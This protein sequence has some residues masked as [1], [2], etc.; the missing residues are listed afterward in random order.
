MVDS[1]LGECELEGEGDGTTQAAFSFH[2]WEVEWRG[3][4]MMK[5]M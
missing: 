2:E 1:W 4:W 5:R 3:Y